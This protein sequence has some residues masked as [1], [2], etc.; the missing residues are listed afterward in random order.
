[1]NIGSKETLFLYHSMFLNC[2][3]WTSENYSVRASASHPYGFLSLLSVEISFSMCI[4]FVVKDLEMFSSVFRKCMRLMSSHSSLICPNTSITKA[5]MAQASKRSYLFGEKAKESQEKWEAAKKQQRL[6]TLWGGTLF[7]HP[8]AQLECEPLSQMRRQAQV[9]LKPLTGLQTPNPPG[10][11]VNHVMFLDLHLQLCSFD[12]VER[13]EAVCLAR[14]SPCGH[15]REEGGCRACLP[16][17]SGTSSQS[18]R[19]FLL[20]PPFS[21][22][23]S[24][25][26]PGPGKDWMN[27]PAYTQAHPPLEKIPAQM[28]MACWSEGPPLLL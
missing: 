26:H 18:R 19:R 28:G 23:S 6:P 13:C 22:P 9:S 12:L 1:M 16:A 11:L 20:R 4:A 24:L 27:T 15:T 10:S 14:Q 2:V 25:L 7:L 17:P 3:W 8:W 5:E 21:Q